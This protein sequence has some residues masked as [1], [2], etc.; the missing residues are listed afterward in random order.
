M[1]VHISLLR[2]VVRLGAV[3]VRGM[4]GRHVGAVLCRVTA[5]SVAS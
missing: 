5:D 2:V 4:A 1:G 3:G